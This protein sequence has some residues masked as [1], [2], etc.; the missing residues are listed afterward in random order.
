MNKKAFCLVLAAILV[1]V[2]LTTT[3]VKASNEGSYRLGY[4]K[5][6]LSLDPQ[7]S[8]DANWYPELK[9]DTCSLSKSYVSD[10]KIMPAVTNTTSCLDGFF[11]GWRDWCSSN[12]KHAVGCIGNLTLGDFPDTLLRSH[13]QYIAGQKAANNIDSTICPVGENA[14]FCLGWANNN[15]FDDEGC[16]DE[17]TSNITTGLVGCIGDTL[18][19]SQIGGLPALV[20]NWHFVNS[21][22]SEDKTPPITGTFL[23]NDNGYLRMVIPNKSGLGDYVKEESWGYLGHRI[24][25]FCNTDGDCQNSTLTMIMPNHMEFIDSNHNTVH[26]MKY[27]PS[28]SFPLLPTAHHHTTP[29]PYY[30]TNPKQTNNNMTTLYRSGRF[31]ADMG[32]NTGAIAIY[33]KALTINPRDVQVLADLGRVLYNLKNYTGALRSED[34]ALSIDPTSIYALEWKGFVLYHLGDYKQ[35][36][37]TTDRALE[38][39]PSDYNT[40]TAKGVTLIAL[41]EYRQAVAIFDEA[42]KANINAYGQT[43]S[44]PDA[45]VTDFNKA[46]ALLRLG[47]QTHAITDIHLALQTVEKSIHFNPDNKGAQDLRLTLKDILAWNDG[48]VQSPD[49]EP[50]GSEGDR[51]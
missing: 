1:L 45:S 3:N 15:T 41:G 30:I 49:A 7:N 2:P 16:A 24:L 19:E 23:F 39:N 28:H 27:N 20:G 9:N 6:Y 33:K 43:Y 32:N 13:Q 10:N 8:P 50:V 31:Q 29:T 21:S 51:Q 17:P 25:T 42:L 35:A 22:S 26:L 48:G 47:Q 34:R 11:Q 14:A 18:T 46:L 38:L 5:A 36:L 12:A 44:Y 4:M 40:W 37:A